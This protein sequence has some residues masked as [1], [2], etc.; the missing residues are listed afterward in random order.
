MISF[1]HPYHDYLPYNGSLYL[2]TVF[3]QFSLLPT[4]HLL[5]HNPDRFFYEFICVCLF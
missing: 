1:C 2:L 4:P 5:N 3:L